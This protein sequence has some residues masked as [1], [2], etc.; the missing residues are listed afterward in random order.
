MSGQEGMRKETDGSSQTRSGREP[1]SFPVEVPAE[2]K[3]CR[4]TGRAPE[5]AGIQEQIGEA[6]G[7]DQPGNNEG[8]KR[9]EMT[10]QDAQEAR[11]APGRRTARNEREKPVMGEIQRHRGR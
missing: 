11:K 3:R 1:G 5:Q 4:D 10:R 8:T 7:E 9:E 6:P 2:G